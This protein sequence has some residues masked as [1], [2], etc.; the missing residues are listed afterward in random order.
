MQYIRRVSLK[1][2]V[3][4]HIKISHRFR[5]LHKQHGQHAMGRACEQNTH[6][7]SKNWD[8]DIAIS[9]KSTDKST[10]SRTFCIHLGQV[11]QEQGRNRLRLS[12]AQSTVWLPSFCSIRNITMPHPTLSLPCP[13][14]T[15]TDSYVLHTGAWW[16]AGEH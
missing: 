7:S 6:F 2:F 16:R 5:H 11:V 8:D 9:V 4:L 12:Q 3:G 13:T 14:Y 15:K 1:Y 10:S